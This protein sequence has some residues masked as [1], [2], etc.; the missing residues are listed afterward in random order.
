MGSHQKSFTLIELLVVI[1]IIAILASILL[2]ALQGAKE[3]AHRIA[4][5]GQQRQIGM[6]A[7]LYHDDNKTY[8]PPSLALSGG[9]ET[10]YRISA[11]MFLNGYTL[12]K[13]GWEMPRAIPG[14]IFYC[15]RNPGNSGDYYGGYA[16]LGKKVNQQVY[17]PS[18]KAYI[19]DHPGRLDYYFQNSAPSG[20]I[21]M[22]GG[23]STS[24]KEFSG[25]DAKRKQDYESGRHGGFVNV[26]FHDFHG[27]ALASQ[28]P[29]RAYY[30]NTVRAETH[31]LEPTVQ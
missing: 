6:L 9:G 3:A 20:V 10:Y 7:R 12:G 1:A 19:I 31:L 29:A 21:Y 8:L 13:S 5:L 15:P 4:C 18:R 27:E 14:K 11:P 2:P 30:I 26:I 25:T 23:F 16:Y 28:I 17:Y 24:G 22:S